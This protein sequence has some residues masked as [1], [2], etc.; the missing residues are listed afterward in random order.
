MGPVWYRCG[1]VWDRF[2]PIGP[3]SSGVSYGKV[4][5]PR[6]GLGSFWV[7]L[8]SIWD[9]FGT[10]LVSIWDRFGV[11][12]GR[13]GVVLPLS[14]H[15]HQGGL[16]EMFM[17]LGSPKRLRVVYAPRFPHKT[18]INQFLAESLMRALWSEPFVEERLMEAL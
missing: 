16:M 9:R 11:D 15:Y 14:V 10:G 8:G 4:H 17:R 13:F 3:L 2:A 12:V 7:G 6:V 18:S 5:A 1:S